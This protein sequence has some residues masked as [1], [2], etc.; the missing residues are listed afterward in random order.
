MARHVQAD[1]QKLKFF[2]T[3][4]TFF[5]INEYQQLLG[6]FSDLCNRLH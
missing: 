2:F 4:A 1:E 5:F 3:I 6:L